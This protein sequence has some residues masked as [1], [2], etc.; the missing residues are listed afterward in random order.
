M[1]WKTVKRLI[2]S[3]VTVVICLAIAGMVFAGECKWVPWNESRPWLPGERYEVV[4][5]DTLDLAHR[6]ELAISA[7][8][9][10]VDLDEPAN[11]EIWFNTLF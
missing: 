11:G 3:V 5:P 4:A 2:L 7:I 9:G 1:S 8:T 10:T 6:A